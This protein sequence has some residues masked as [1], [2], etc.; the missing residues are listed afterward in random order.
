MMKKFVGFC[1]VLFAL[2]VFSQPLMAEEEDYS[3]EPWERAALYLGAFFVHNDSDLELGE[4]AGIN[5]DGED[6]LDLDEDITVFRADAF[7]R[8]TRRNRVDFTYYA[9]NRDGTTDLNVDIPLPGGGSY[10]EGT[11]I[12]TNF[13]MTI[14]RASYA[15]SFFKNDH[16]DLS[17][18]GGLYGLAVDFEMKRKGSVGSGKEETDFMF[19]LPVVGLRGNFALT[20]KWF[21][22]QSFDYFYVNWG[23][24]EG[25]LIDL[26]VAV[27]WNALKYLGLGVGYNYV[28]MNL[29][30]NGS[31]DFLSE[32]DLNN[33]GVLAFAKL[34]F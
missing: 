9:M 26:L 17:I 32:I 20:P 16:F 34:Y 15:W 24:Y 12:K 3:N 11:R 33:G 25:Y 21:I 31:D 22:R 30:Y 29:D 5:I 6:A 28:Q 19:P 8:I 2:G 27:E 13:D 14:L 18:A 4:G 1:L 10:Q 23:D 7:W